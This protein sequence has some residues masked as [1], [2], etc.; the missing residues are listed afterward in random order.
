MGNSPTRLRMP[1]RASG[2]VSLACA[3]L[4][5]GC[6]AHG[7]ARNG[8]K[9]HRGLSYSK[10]GGSS[11]YVDLYVPA[12]R[13]PCP[14]VVWYHGGSW[15]YG[16]PG[17]HLLLRD[18]TDHGFA[19]ASVKY[20]LLGRTHRWPAQLEDSL[21]AVD[22]VYAN[23]HR[24]GIDASRLGVSGESAGGHLA[25][26]VALRV[27]RPRIDAA[28]VLYPPTDM[29]ELGRRYAHFHRFSVVTQM[30]R[31][32]IENRLDQA[33][34][35]SP[36]T[37]VSRNAPPFLIIHGDRDWLVPPDQSRHLHRALKKAGAESHL[38]IVK[39]KGH[40]FALDDGQ[41]DE[42]AHFFRR[43]L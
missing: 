13:K 40:A 27:G 3:I 5:T 1:S 7:P 18:L 11:Q 26:L 19:V 42:V 6:A 20:R 16:H 33:R 10:N 41:L 22:W 43:R 23:G 28:C 36:L 32:D 12:S 24:Y 37:Y 9:I 8:E 15:K 25:A 29:V 30:F 31:G 34:A 17:F 38:D 39:G 4:F 2:I 21:A 14:V 35:A